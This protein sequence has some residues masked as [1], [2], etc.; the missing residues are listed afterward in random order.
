MTMQTKLLLLSGVLFSFLSVLFGA[1]GAHML[2]MKLTE[3][4]LQIFEVGVRYQ[5]FHALSLLGIAILSHLFPQLNMSVC[6]W[7][8]LFGIIFFSFSLYILS[9]FNIR[10]MGMITPIGGMLFL[11]SWGIL[12]FK[13][14]KI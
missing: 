9:I 8:F 13:I 3:E 12:F 4:Y 5:F 2:K 10:W 14:V 1:F 7:L 6:G 11:I